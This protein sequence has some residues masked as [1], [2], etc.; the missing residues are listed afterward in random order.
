L[1][2]NPF[3]NP[4]LLPENS[5]RTSRRHGSRNFLVKTRPVARPAARIKESG[6]SRARRFI[7]PFERAS[8]QTNAAL[9]TPRFF[10]KMGRRK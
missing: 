10:I 1:F 2:Q 5:R 4:F 7:V 6:C 9:K 8:I 3:F